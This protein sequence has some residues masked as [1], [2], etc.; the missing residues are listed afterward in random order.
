MSG[1]TELLGA[2]LLGKDGEV[3]TAVALKDKTA[4][5]L[6]FS[7]HWCPPCRGFT[8]QL[9][10]WYTE[11]LKAKGLEVVFVSSDRDEN[12]FKEYYGEQPW[13][14]L[15]FGDRANKEALS[16]KFKVKG[17]PAVVV[18]GPDGETITLDGRTAISNDPKGMEMPLGWKPKTFSEIFND[19]TL[20]G[21]GDTKK[22]GSDLMGTVF[23][24]YFSAHWCPPCRGF[25][26]QLAESYNKDLKQKGF[27]V[28]F[29]SGDK[30]EDE[31]QSYF[32]EQPWLAL[33]FGDS[34]RKN[35]LNAHFGVEGIP[36]FVIVDKDGSVITKNGT[37]VV[38]GDPTGQEFPWY[39][40]PV[41]NLKDGPGD[42]NEVTTVFALCETQD[43]ATQKAI[44]A[45][46]EPFAKKFKA[47]AK[48]KGEEVPAIA[49][50]IVTENKGIAPRI[51]SMMKLDALPP[52]K[53][54]HPLEKKDQVTG[55]GCDGCSKSGE[56]KDRYRCT[57]GCDFDLCGECNAKAEAGGTVNMAPQLMLL[58]IPDNGGYFKGPEGD[59]TSD[60]V[61]KLIDDYKSKALERQQLG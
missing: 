44:E 43:Q 49:F 39:P 32:K 27:E 33:D 8:P 51:R 56:G 47:E 40:K 22:K 48:A 7:G 29:V 11:D 10:G 61:Q 3:D 1:L 13:L 35:Q 45:V 42:I 38:K 20:V 6:Y 15:P 9:A 21:P 17:I 55:W 26:P 19:A 5:A 46:F 4:V 52:S 31:F 37:S 60:T 23:G 50:T 58:D 24:V 53:H 54:E 14:A 28:V 59:V 25:T 41:T 12:A 16:K 36:C 34:K 18:L 57:A 30:S 2:K